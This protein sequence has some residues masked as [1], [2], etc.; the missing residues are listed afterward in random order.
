MIGMNCTKRAPHS[1]RRKRYTSRAA[2]AVRGVD[3][4]ERV[5]L[6]ARRAQVIEPAHHLVERCRGRPC[7]RGRCRAA[8]AGRRSRRRRGS[9]CSLKNAAHSA[10]SSVP[11]VW[12]VYAARW[13]G[14]RW[15]CAISTERRKKSSA[16][17]RRLAAL[18]RDRHLGHARVRLDQ[19]A[20]VRLEQLVGHAEA[21]A[22]VEHLLGEEEAVRA[23]EVADRAR[24][25]G[26][27]VE[28]CRRACHRRSI[29]RS[30]RP[31]I[32]PSGRGGRVRPARSSCSSADAEADRH[33]TKR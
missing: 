9:S 23:V 29:A 2:V 18:P 1:S 14:C 3:G 19:L 10:S 20:Q 8:R 32:A 6:D 31:H 12:I 33:V 24:R 27:Q 26:E 13:P 22:R 5:P 17:Q 4:R 30:G 28:G 7:S 21:R 16:H 25:L 15:R 11:F